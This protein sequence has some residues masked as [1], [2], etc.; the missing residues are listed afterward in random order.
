MD[1]FGQNELYTKNKKA[2]LKVIDNTLKGQSFLRGRAITQ[3]EKEV[4]FL[5]SRKYAI[6]VNSGTDAILIALQSLGIEKGDEVIVPSF[7]FIASVTPILRL[8]AIPVFVDVDRDSCFIQMSKIEEKITKKTKGIIIVDIFG[9]CCDYSQVKSLCKKYSIFCLED[10][11]QSFG[12]SFFNKKAGKLGDVSTFSFDVSKVVHG[13]TTGGMIL[14]DNSK[15]A[16][17]AKAIR[18]HGFIP[19]KRDFIYL[20]LNSQMS[21]ANAALI[22]YNLKIEK[23]NFFKRQRVRC[24]YD[25]F[26]SKIP[27]ICLLKRPVGSFGNNH[28]YVIFLKNN[29]DTLFNF[30]LSNNIPVKIHYDKSLPEYKNI[31]DYVK[32]ENQPN[33]KYISRHIISLPIHPYL[34][35]DD[36]NKVCKTIK[37]FF[38]NEN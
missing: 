16:Q 10:A 28:K 30:L 32:V 11:A 25:K 24:F 34:S 18:G 37:R 31:K 4:A 23:E 27:Q 36:L 7:S 33:A 15:I 5:C 8:G 2:Y 6:C 35:L 13:I 20:G 3:L 17:K 26:L 19:Q 1:F 38:K 9:E 22:L 12:S 21:S 14:T 29:R